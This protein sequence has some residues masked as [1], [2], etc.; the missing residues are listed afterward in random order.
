MSPRSALTRFLVVVPVA[1]F[2]LLGTSL[3]GSALSATTVDI[4]IASSADDA[5]HDPLCCWP[6]YSDSSTGRGIFAGR[7]GSA[8]ATWGGWRWANLN[9]PANAVVREAYVKFVQRGYGYTFPTNLAFQDASGTLSFSPANSPY[10]RW[11]VRTTFQIQWT[12]PKAKPGAFIQTPDLS[13]GIQE[14]ISRHG[15]LDSLVLIEDGTPAPQGQ[16][17]EWESY[18]TNSALAAVLHIVYTGGGTVTDQTPP[19]R[20][21]GRPSGSFSAGTTEVTLSLDT[22]ENAGCKFDTVAGVGYSAMPNTFATTGANVHRQVVAARDGE[23]YT[24]YVKCQDSSGNANSDDFPIAFSVASPGPAT[25]DVQVSSSRDDAFHDPLC[26]WP[27]YSHTSSTVYAGRPGSSGPVWGGWRWTNLALPRGARITKA[28]IDFNQQGYGYLFP[29][30]VS[31]ENSPDPQPFSS[32]SSPYHRW[33]HRTSF[34]L[35][36][37][38]PKK[39][40]GSWVRTPDLSQGLQELI[41][42]YGTISSLVFLED[43]TLALPK[44]YHTW[45]SYEANPLLAARLHIEY[46]FGADT[47]PPLRSNG[48]PTGALLSATRETTLRL[49]TDENAVCRYGTVPGIPY[50][51][52]PQV[53]TTTGGTSHST[54]VTGLSQ[55]SSYA[56]YV[57]CQDTTGNA[58][59]DDYRI[60]FRIGGGLMLLGS[61]D[62]STKT[63][64]DVWGEGNFAYL[65]HYFDG[66]VEIIDITDPT[67]PVLAFH[68]VLPK[69]RQLKD[70]KVQN[71][72]GY[73]ASDTD[74]GVWIVDLKDPYR[75]VNIGQIAVPP[76]V[77]NLFVSGSYLYLASYRDSQ[78]W[79][80]DVRNPSSPALA[81]IVPQQGSGLVHDVVVIG[82]R[83]FT[84]TNDGTCDI[85][86]VSQL[87]AVMPLGFFDCGD[88]ADTGWTDATGRYLYI[89]REYKTSAGP[90]EI[91]D[92]SNP[93][94]ASKVKEIFG[95]QTS[96]HPRRVDNLLYVSWWGGG[97][98]VF[99][100][101]DP[102]N[103]VLVG[104]YDTTAGEKTK[105]IGGFDGNWGVY[106]FSGHQ[107]VLASDTQ[108]GLFIFDASELLAAN[109]P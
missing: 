76:G 59:P 65:G 22:N 64:G 61:W 23:S 6:G 1:I 11:A 72:T 89:G 95:G 82:N 37:T 81:A 12:W 86:D 48:Q 66:S 39:T 71:S 3:E 101:S 28:Y 83:M 26:C 62:G 104:E 98:N 106:P 67:K 60:G 44:Q 40:P 51:S 42:R 16:S 73:F 85:F 41:N 8:G 55:G 18:D 108:H 9:I 96:H 53:F 54:T 78:T 46:T 13:Q 88:N 50:S 74:G 5:F 34:Q 107:R 77:H 105:E 91:W 79:I 7:P 94:N 30:N 75:P 25:L 84:F 38:W 102:I 4:R 33:Q 69:G 63:Y 32:L 87:P 58:N 29:T 27:G 24:Y 109:S 35:E 45:A 56:F 49:D 68:W 17:H 31:F 103:P 19:V 47:S 90:M 15:A 2:A 43:G 92:I 70:G 93:A 10:H 80:Y 57:K 97:L 14:L 100:I 36:W 52:M 99:D 20:S 21:N